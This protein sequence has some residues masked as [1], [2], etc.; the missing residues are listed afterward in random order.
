[1]LMFCMTMTVWML[2]AI[3]TDWGLN[4]SLAVTASG[5]NNKLPKFLNASTTI[6]NATE[7][8]LTSLLTLSII[9]NPTIS[10]HARGDG[11][12]AW[13]WERHVRGETSSVIHCCQILYRSAAFCPVKCL[14]NNIGLSHLEMLFDKLEELGDIPS[15]GVL[16]L[17]CRQKLIIRRGDLTSFEEHLR[18]THAVDNNINWIIESTLTSQNRQGV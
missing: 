3:S 2:M 14:N 6:N 8:S 5:L 16:C 17:L 13:A 10:W 7:I 11:G 18:K 1:M 12:E 9:N 4:Y 15:N